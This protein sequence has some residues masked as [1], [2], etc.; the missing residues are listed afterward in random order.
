[1]GL[2]L[3][4]AA[5]SDSVHECMA[6]MVAR[7]IRHLPIVD[8]ESG[9]VS[10]IPDFLQPSLSLAK[11]RPGAAFRVNG[12]ESTGFDGTV[13]PCGEAPPCS[14]RLYPR[15]SCETIET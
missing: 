3:V 1:M 8:D 9:Q 5:K 14:E 6:K 4:V 10:A 12:R 2:N 11:D 7:D 15:P 13:A